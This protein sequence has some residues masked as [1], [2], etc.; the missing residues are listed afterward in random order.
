MARTMRKADEMFPLVEEY[1]GGEQTKKVFCAEH[2]VSVPVFS[3]WMRRY[4]DEKT[5][6]SAAFVEIVPP[7]SEA[8]VVEISYPSGVRVRFFSAVT[9]GY[10]A[11]LISAAR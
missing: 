2:G 4:R 10:L 3:Y 1:L 9:P 6:R 8:S 7:A 11:E 5:D